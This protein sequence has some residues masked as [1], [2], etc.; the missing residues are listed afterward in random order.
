MVHHLQLV[1]FFVEP[2]RELVH[3]RL[4]LVA[5]EAALEF[6]LLDFPVKQDVGHAIVVALLGRGFGGPGNF[7]G[8]GVAE[9]VLVDLREG[10]GLA[11]EKISALA[12]NLEHL[13]HAVLGRRKDKKKGLC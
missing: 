3:Q 4:N 9:A 13:P 2:R 5:R 7:R 1:H 6:F 10:V 12:K 11:V 8:K